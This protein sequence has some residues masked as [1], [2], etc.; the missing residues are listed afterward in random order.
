MITDSGLGKA[1]IDA[2]ARTDVA[3]FGYS[4]VTP[5]VP[6]LGDWTGD[7][8]EIQDRL[9]RIIFSSVLGALSNPEVVERGSVGFANAISNTVSIILAETGW[10]DD[11]SPNR[12]EVKRDAG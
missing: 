3:K 11:G 12:I 1:A 9:A 5:A 4:P 7:Q 2:M 6:L 8:V 10:N